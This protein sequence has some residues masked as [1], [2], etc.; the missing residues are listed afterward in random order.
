MNLF[1]W[2]G[3]P[4]TAANAKAYVDAAAFDKVR[5]PALLREEADRQ[6]YR[7][8]RVDSWRQELAG[9]EVAIIERLT[10]KQMAEFGYQPLAS[11][12]DRML[13]AARLQS[14]RLANKFAKLVRA[15]A[16]RIK[17]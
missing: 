2:I 10:R 12:G 14:Y 15:S 9:S 8:G 1:E 13:A 7:R 16:D 11:R 3:E 5:P 4:I 17:P 6:F